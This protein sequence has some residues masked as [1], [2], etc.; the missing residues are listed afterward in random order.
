MTKYIN[1]GILYLLLAA[2]MQTTAFAQTFSE[3]KGTK[4]KITLLIP[5]YL[6]SAFDAGK[7]RYG[8][9]MPT[10]IANGLDFYNG[11]KIAAN[12]LES[13]GIAALI[14]VIDTKAPDFMNEYF[15]DTATEGTGIVIAASQS[16][17]EMKIIAEKLRPLG[18]PLI[19]MLPNDAGIGGYP[20]MMLANST[21]KTHCEQIFRYLQRNNSIDNLVMLTP[22]GSAESR[23][24]QYLVEE[25]KNTPSIP[26]KWREAELNEAATPESLALLLDSNRMNVIIAPTLNGAHA[27]RMVKMLSSLGPK[28]RSAVFG[29][30]TWETV[31]FTKTEYRG[32][33][34]WYGTPFVSLSGNAEL[35]EDFTKRF[36]ELTNARP[37]DMG[38][39]GYEITLRY[40]KTYMAYPAEFIK[41]INDRQFR[42][43][44]DFEFKPVSLRD[45]G[46]IDYRENKKVYL[47]KKTDGVIK[48]VVT[49]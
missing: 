44:N 6:D 28:Y 36:K 24:K 22:H 35:T 46:Q 29:M 7:Y 19:S 1:F 11:A 21:L 32:V 8:N 20:Q 27:Q 13:A 40:L 47:I 4:P 10:H 37:G 18:I 9:T 31:S 33:D 30:P 15:R 45:N 48:T 2:G 49:P 14:R 16:A 38:F 43:F 41:H 5:L 34:V 26:L 25:N 3:Q 17:A 23:L 12:E 39:R 42:M